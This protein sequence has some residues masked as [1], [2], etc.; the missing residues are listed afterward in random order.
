MRH[1]TPIIEFLYTILP[2]TPIA[3]SPRYY[4]IVE[5]PGNNGE[6][7]HIHNYH[8]ARIISLIWRSDTILQL[9]YFDADVIID[10]TSPTSLTLLEEEIE[11]YK[12]S[13]PQV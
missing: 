3:G 6:S 13:L 9:Y 11:R 12:S 8:G 2:R 4:E 5:Q 1:N 10:L 7:M